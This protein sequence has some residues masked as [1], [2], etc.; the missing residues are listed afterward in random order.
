MSEDKIDNRHCNEC[1]TLLEHHIS[2]T[3]VTCPDC[4]RQ[5]CSPDC[6]AEHNGLGACPNADELPAERPQ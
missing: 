3:I 2:D 6:M 4:L 5:Y 1:G